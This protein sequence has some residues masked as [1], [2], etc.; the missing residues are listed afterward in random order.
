[1]IDC[2]YRLT[3]KAKGKME[4][5][6]IINPDWDFTKMGIGGLGDEFNAIFR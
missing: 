5:Q 4:R 1:M 6:S 3:G 2:F